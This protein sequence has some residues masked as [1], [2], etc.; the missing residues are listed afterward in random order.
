MSQRPSRVQLPK[1]A[2]EDAADAYT[3]YVMILGISEEVFWWA[4][5]SFL[6]SVDLNKGAYDGWENAEIERRRREVRM[7]AGKKR[8]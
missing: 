6:K 4:D 1:F 8:G 5:I 7:R 3:Y 2:I